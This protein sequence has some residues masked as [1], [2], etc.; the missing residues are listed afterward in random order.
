MIEGSNVSRP[1]PVD[2]AGMLSEMDQALTDEIEKLSVFKPIKHSAVDGTLLSE[3]NGQYI[4]QFTLTEPWE[5][6]DD[7]PLSIANANMQRTNC[8]VVNSTGTLL[9][10]ASDRPLP[11]EALRQIDLYD[12]STE[13]LKRLKEALKQVDE[14]PANL[15]SKSFGLL[16]SAENSYPGEITSGKF[17][18]RPKQTQA[19]RLSLGGE[20]AFIV[21]P[22][23]TGKTSTLAAI[24]LQHLQAGRKVLIAAHTNIAIDNAIMKLCELC[25]E[26]RREDLLANGQVV[27]YGAVQ[28]DELKKDDN[29][30]EVFLPKIAQHMGSKLH[31]QHEQFKAALAG[32]DSQINTLQQKKQAEEEPRQAEYQRTQIDLLH[33]ELDPLEQAE[34]QRISS[35]QQQQ[36][37][38]QSRISQ[39]AGEERPLSQDLARTEARIVEQEQTLAKEQ[40]HKD[41][42]L[43]QL[44]EAR[45]MSRAKRF[46]K[47]LKLESLEA[48]VSAAGQAAN[49]LER[50]LTDLKTHLATRY[51][52]L[53]QSRQQRQAI[54]SALNDIQQQLN[55]PSVDARKISALKEQLQSQKRRL[56]E[57]DALL[58]R[59]EQQHQLN[60]NNFAAQRSQ[61]EAQIADVDKRLRDI[62]KGIVENARVVGTTLTKTYI[63]PTMASKRFEAVILD[64]VSMAPLPLVY[65]AA[66][67]ADSSVTLIGDP[68]QLAPIVNA[69]TPMTK[70][71]LE[72]D[73]FGLREVSLEAAIEGKNHSVMLNVQSRMHPAIASIANKHV[74]DGKLDNAFNEQT[75]KKITPLPDFPLVLCDTHDASPTVT[76]PPNGKSRK[77]YYHALCCLALARQVLASAPEMKQQSEHCIG[78]VTPYRPQ[79]LLLQNLIRD[80][81]LQKWVQ[82][83]T[84]HRFQGLEFDVVIFDTVES[85]G[86]AP[87]DFIAGLKESNSMRLIN[88]AVT[89]PKHKLYIVANLPHLR[90]ALPE[91]STLL[92]AV[93]EAAKS[94]ILPSL[95][96][97]GTPFSALV[98]KMREQAPSAANTLTVLN[99][100]LSN[101]VPQNFNGAIIDAEVLVY[102]N[103]EQGRPISADQQNEP[104]IQHYTEVTFYDAFKH[105]I[106]NARESIVIASPFMAEIRLG[107]VLPLIVEQK[108]KGI[109]ISIFTKPLDESKKWINPVNQA[110]I[111]GIEP[112]Y[113]PK[114]HE[115]VVLIDEKILYHGSLNILSQRD[116][117]ESMLRVTN[118][119]VVK[120]VYESLKLSGQERLQIK[121]DDVTFKN[122]KEIVISVKELSTATKCTCGNFLVPR[123]RKDGSGVFFGCSQ[124]NESKD[125]SSENVLESHLQRITKIQNQVCTKCGNQTLLQIQDRPQRVL[126]VCDANCGEMQKIT[127]VR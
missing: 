16:D 67:R 85:P 104:E 42:A 117:E 7:G 70:K 15:R 20:V 123:L 105:D 106:Q 88:V 52:L 125:K 26:T 71:W 96:I 22:P 11:P 112:V 63:N 13:L 34:A 60:Y 83:G 84:V 119:R 111:E 122:L 9:T 66:S 19:A 35:L 10:I 78:I 3:G 116:S 25:K 54:E 81:G 69:K 55:T 8:T 44:V 110:I 72:R 93:E 28:K 126:L 47:G 51:Q 108:N 90:Q 12:D 64:E 18:L 62:E 36:S 89:R 37:Q 49:D 61:L 107:K 121:I 58:K 115:K 43:K 2:L 76:R 77:N 102:R 59:S 23:G 92:S 30:K 33:K 41:I 120:D 86:L 118:S 75:L 103:T 98:S 74:Y 57:I 31:I 40:Q 99:K 97:V 80:E 27:R 5:P 1:A 56:A 4:Y 17:P 91:R 65:V 127:F 50:S 39:L 114:M 109:K 53:G 6:Q 94:V 82:A 68:Q 124:Y 101:R 73:L 87:G 24:A 14:G 79:L 95:D 29:Y 45:A 100:V 21:G 46:F 113:K 48:K 38:Y 32:L